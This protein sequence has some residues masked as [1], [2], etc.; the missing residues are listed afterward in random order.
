MLHISPER[1]WTD[2]RPDCPRPHYWHAT[3]NQ[4]TEV[5]VSQLVGAFVRALQPEYVV[6]TGT[7][8]GQT[9]EQIGL[10][11]LANGHGELDTLE[12]NDQYASLAWERCEGLPVTIHMGPSLEFTPRGR[13]GFAWFDSLMEL[14]IPEFQRFRRYLAPGAV[15]GF[16]DTGPH[17][18]DLGYQVRSLPGV[19][20]LQLPTPR[21][22][23]FLQER[24]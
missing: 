4:S 3:D 24:A 7:C 10:A 2:P 22:V 8:I 19:Q 23:T 20:T 15:C 14:R 17:K 18:G 16:H 5:E 6:E 9:S 12:V 13:I 21:G 11:L 1:V